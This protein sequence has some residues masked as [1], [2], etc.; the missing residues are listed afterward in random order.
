MKWVTDDI[1]GNSWKNELKNVAAVVS[2]L[3]AFGSNEVIMNPQTNYV[4]E[5]VDLKCKQ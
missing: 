3:G 5:E 1:C 2:C 4:I